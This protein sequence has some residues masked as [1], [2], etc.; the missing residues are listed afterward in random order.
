MTE[1]QQP[2]SQDDVLHELDEL[3]SLFLQCRSVFPAM[4]ESLLG[5]TSF[6]TGSYYLKK[7]YA[8]QVQLKDPIDADFIE[9]NRR[10][11]KWINEN[12]IARL[13]GIMHHHKLLEEIDKTT[14]GWK[15]VDLMRRMRNVFTKTRLGYRPN[16]PNNQK[17]REEVVKHF[18]LDENDCHEEEIPT[19]INN[20]RGASVLWLSGIC[21]CQVHR[22]TKPS[23]T[24]HCVG[25]TSAP[26][27]GAPAGYGNVM[28]EMSHA[29]IHIKER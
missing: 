22:I 23:T 25:W 12:A 1:S 7:G 2:A 4:T 14:S 6:T 9:R 18:Q 13:Y 3:W 10:M 5:K 21:L 29:E 28:C 24:A 16:S 15:E 11:G 20:R 27:R 26:L 8:A 17:L 19:P